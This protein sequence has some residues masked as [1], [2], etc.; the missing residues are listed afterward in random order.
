MTSLARNERG[1]IAALSA[2]VIPVFLLL[3]A[4]VLDA[5]NWYAHK[6]ALQNRADAAA[7]AAGG[8]YAAQ[9]AN[10]VADS[11]TAGSV[12]VA[13]ARRYAG[14]AAGDFNEGV[15][16]QAN[17][18]VAVNATGPGAPDNSSGVNP[19]Q[20][21]VTGDA[22]SD[23]GWVGTDVIVQESNIG[24]LG[25]TL[26]IN[27]PSITARARVELNEM[28]ETDE[29]APLAIPEQSIAKARI[30]F[31]D[32]CSGAEL[33]SSALQPLASSSQTVPGMSLWGPD[34]SGSAG[35][36]SLSLPGTVPVP[37]AGGCG[38]PERDYT[39]IR[40][41]LRLAGAPGIDLSD[42]VSCGALQSMSSAD[43]YPSI[44]QIRVYKG[45]GGLVGDRPQIREVE[46]TPSGARP[47]VTDVYYARTT[48]SPDCTFD[49]SVLMDW[50]SRPS[51]RA[52]FSASIQVG[53]GPT[54]TLSGPTPQ[55][56]W[57]AFQIPI[58][59][60]GPDEVRVSWRYE[61]RR[62]SWPPGGLS[63]CTRSNPCVQ[64]GTTAVHQTNLADD[65][66][67]T[68]SSPTDIV[69]A[70]K[71]T[72]G[73][74]ITSGEL[75]EGRTNTVITPYVTVGL[76]TVFQPGDW[77]TVRLSENSKSFAVV[78]DP[79]WRQPS[80]GDVTAA[81]YF[82]CQP[83]YAPN[84]T[85][86]DWYWWSTASQSCPAAG[87][88]LQLPSGTWPN[89][90]YA[91]SPWRCVELD[92]DG[93]GQATGD[94]IALATGNCAAA[95]VV[96]DPQP[97]VGARASCTSSSYACNNDAKY[98]G[99]G[100]PPSPSDPRVVKVFV[101]PWNAYKGVKSGHATAVPVV[102][103]AAFYITAWKF[104]G[105]H[106][107]C[108]ATNP[109]VAADLAK[110]GPGDGKVGGYFVKAVESSGPATSTKPCNPDDVNVCQISLT[111]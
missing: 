71:L 50:G 72:S 105:R 47:C 54:R 29:F 81:F 16:D 66:Q 11:A 61:L 1:G 13:Q 46:L 57:S 109:Q 53:N 62:G 34:P 82:G 110:L 39:P 20:K 33:A 93:I 87:S 2:L 95:D 88:Y 5:G 74:S 30:R 75:H 76:R 19:C 32:D 36:V 6:R 60:L 80:T 49:A 22:I 8:E 4:L 17:V 107:P 58:D 27:L 96:A 21:H 40:V 12:I 102:R 97:G 99:T 65:P 108:A 18:T 84:D 104:D 15:N 7:L 69:G 25:R 98:F 10:C 9:L 24:T 106:D 77:A 23:P 44:S 78:C 48:A 90:T 43:C 103:L 70:V 91:G 31:V 85:G 37:G 56:A 52:T 51:T 59:R 83:Q 89:Q 86:R 68:Q 3:G 38:N 100:A 14:A 79:N 26:G 35:T 28:P 42:A 111:R 101:V 67:D 73:P 94:G 55:G 63:G 64:Q 45:S 41:E 92:P